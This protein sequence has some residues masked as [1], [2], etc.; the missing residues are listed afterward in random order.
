MRLTNIKE[1]H[2]TTVYSM[3]EDMKKKKGKKKKYL[4]VLQFK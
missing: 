3:K 4:A 1:I 2:A